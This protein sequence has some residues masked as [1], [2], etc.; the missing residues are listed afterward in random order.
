M[1]LHS[2]F[3]FFIKQS[4]HLTNMFSSYKIENDRT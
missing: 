1:F 3:D 2:L 4:I